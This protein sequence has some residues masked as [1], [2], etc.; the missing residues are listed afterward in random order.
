MDAKQIEQEVKS[1]VAQV[2]GAVKAEAVK[3]EDELEKA[4]QV[5]RAEGKRLLQEEGG[6][7]LAAERAAEAAVVHEY[8]EFTGAVKSEIDWAEAW[9]SAKGALKVGAIALAAG[10][11]FVGLCWLVSLV[12]C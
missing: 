6:K 7:A 1:E 12:H 5:T 10:A 4:V 2:E 11:G 9:V 8:N 3:V